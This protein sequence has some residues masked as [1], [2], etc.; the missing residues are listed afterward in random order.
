MNLC[1][2]QNTV[3]NSTGTN[4]CLLNVNVC[5]H[6]HNIYIAFAHQLL[7]LI[8]YVYIITILIIGIAY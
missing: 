5:Q 8:N 6:T 3:D 1:S 7:L 2:N 4:I